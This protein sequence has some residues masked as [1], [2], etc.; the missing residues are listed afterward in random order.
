M[1]SLPEVGNVSLNLQNPVIQKLPEK[2]KNEIEKIRDN[3]SNMINVAAVCTTDQDQKLSNTTTSPVE[4]VNYYVQSINCDFKNNGVICGMTFAQS[5]ELMA[6][7]L[8][9][10]KS[11][12]L[13]QCGNINLTKH[14]RNE[15]NCQAPVIKK[16]P[17]KNTDKISADN[18]NKVS[19]L[20]V[21]L[22]SPILPKNKLENSNFC[23]SLLGQKFF[24]RFLGEL[25]KPKCPLEIN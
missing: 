4:T 16:L 5:H 9:H 15:R 6:H 25:K 10:K 1:I 8:S 23:P 2:Y 17:E 18:S 19:K 14:V 13:F 22:V 11:G 7:K 21:I 12:R 20:D 3:T 24:V